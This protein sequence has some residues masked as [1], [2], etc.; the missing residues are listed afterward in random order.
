MHADAQWCLWHQ[1]RS[2]GIFNFTE[3]RGDC[4]LSSVVGLRKQNRHQKRTLPMEKKDTY[5][6]VKDEIGGMEFCFYEII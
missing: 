3:A 1:R 2:W 6:T 4:F 5:R